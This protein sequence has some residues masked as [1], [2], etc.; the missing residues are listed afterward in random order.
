MTKRSKKNVLEVSRELGRYSIDA[1]E[2]L[3]RGLDYTVQKAHGPPVPGVSE[4]AEWLQSH[5]MDM[6][7][8]HELIE[9]GE[10]PESLVQYIDQIGGMDQAAQRLNRHVGGEELCWGLRDLALERWGFMASTVLRHW[11]IR[12]TKDFGRMVFAL[13]E[14]ELLQKQPDDRIEDFENVYNFDDALDRS[15]KLACTRTAPPDSPSE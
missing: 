4:L 2:F 10:I 6:G 1:F 7:E 14:N 5:G 9:G 13:V 12:N 3:H 15:Y 8:L 11:G